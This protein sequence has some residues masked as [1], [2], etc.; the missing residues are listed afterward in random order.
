MNANI[1]HLLRK[2]LSTYIL[3][4]VGGFGVGVLASYI[5]NMIRKRTIVVVPAESTAKPYLAVKNVIDTELLELLE[6]E[7]RINSTIETEDDASSIFVEDAIETNPINIFTIPGG[8]QWDEEYEMSQRTHDAPYIIHADDYV[9]DEFGFKQETVTY[10]EGDDIMA[11]MADVPIY[12]W[13]SMMGELRWGHGSKDKNVVYIRNETMRKEWE[14][15]RES[16]SFEEIVR[17]LDAEGGEL[18]HSLRKF[19]DD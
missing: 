12:N 10:Y 7:A 3:S 5:P 15:L 14:V 1:S 16:G 6:E 8:D 4:G 18:K 2:P 17:G 9:S 13:T 11:T 19:R